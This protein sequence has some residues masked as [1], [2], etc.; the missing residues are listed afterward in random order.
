[1]A[2]YTGRLHRA[3]PGKAEVRIYDFVDSR[4][5]VLAPM[6]QRRLAGL[7]GYQPDEIAEE[8]ELSVFAPG[9]VGT[10]PW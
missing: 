10:V 2:R 9:T 1:M 6:F 5:P 3:H 8:A 4:V 7:I